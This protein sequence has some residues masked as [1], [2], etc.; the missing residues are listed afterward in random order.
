V[1]CI[2]LSD[3][4]LLVVRQ[5][6]GEGQPLLT[7]VL[8]AEKGASYTNTDL[9]EL[10]P[11]SILKR[12]ITSE[13]LSRT[14]LFAVGQYATGADEHLLQLWAIISTSETGWTLSDIFAAWQELS[15]F[16]NAT[17]LV[18][19]QI[20]GTLKCTTARFW[21]TQLPWMWTWH[22]EKLFN[23]TCQQRMPIPT[24]L[25]I[26]IRHGTTTP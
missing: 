21:L 12:N 26:S 3:V 4:V 5:Y 2:A 9:C 20:L 11:T 25:V 19:G 8:T 16:L 14:L 15:L 13:T 18:P 17:S 7:G 22:M 10:V 6:R 1:F 23:L 24:R